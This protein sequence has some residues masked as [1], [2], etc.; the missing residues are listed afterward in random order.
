M[1]EQIASDKIRKI[2]DHIKANVLDPAEK[3]KERLIEEGKEERARIITEAEEESRKIIEQAENHAKQLNASLESALRLSAQQAI[4]ALKLSIETEI[5]K[6]TI[7]DPVGEVLDKQELLKDIIRQI[8]AKYVENDFSGGVEMLLSAE[9]REKLSDYMHSE[10]FEKLKGG[11]SLTEESGIS[12]CKV[13]FKDRRIMIELS[14]E[15]VTELLAGYLRPE[16][17]TYLFK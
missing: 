8:V 11:I 16:I 12:G 9:N 2:S 17:R 6:D 15:S 4:P 13:I 7:Q 1:D 3:E 10:I 14:D 5:L